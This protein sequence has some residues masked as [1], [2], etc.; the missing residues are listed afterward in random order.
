MSNKIDYGRRVAQ[1]LIDDDTES[2][3]RFCKKHRFGAEFHDPNCVVRDAYVYLGELEPYKAQYNVHIYAVTRVKVCNVSAKSQEEA[4]EWAEQNTPLHTLLNL[5]G[6]EI[7]TDSNSYV[8]HAEFSEE[9]VGFLVDEIADPHFL[10]SRQYNANGKL[11]STE[12]TTKNLACVRT[13]EP[14]NV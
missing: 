7:P 9:I 4:I 5:R 6:I 10:N 1:K 3:C 14:K 13:E 2:R 12:G 11:I 8:D